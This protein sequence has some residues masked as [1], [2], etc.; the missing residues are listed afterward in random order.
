M[1]YQSF[2]F[3]VC[4]KTFAINEGLVPK[5]PRFDRFFKVIYLERG[6]AIGTL[7]FLA[8]LVLIGV[9]VLQWKS[10][11]FRTSRLRCDH[12]LGDPGRDPDVAGLSNRSLEFF[13][14]CSGNEASS[15]S[16]SLIEA[17]TEFDA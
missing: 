13:R 6:L 10:S 15:I 12:A 1:G 3:A 4:A 17:E 5:D 8:G 11:G 14:K 9:V 2:L 16:Q 7:A